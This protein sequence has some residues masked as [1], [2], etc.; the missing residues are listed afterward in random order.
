MHLPELVIN[1]KGAVAEKLHGG[2]P[3][4]WGVRV[5]ARVTDPTPDG[6]EKRIE[7][8]EEDDDGRVLM[9]ARTFAVFSGRAVAPKHFNDEFWELRDES[10]VALCVSVMIP[11]RTRGSCTRGPN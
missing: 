7:D 4:R 9:G 10:P 6:G 5:F 1:P 3:I 8:E 2:N 11:T